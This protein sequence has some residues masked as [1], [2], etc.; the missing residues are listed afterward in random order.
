MSRNI[1]PKMVSVSKN[2]LLTSQLFQTLVEKLSESEIED[3][4][5]WLQLVED[6]KNNDKKIKR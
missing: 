6:E 1:Y 3:F 5:R 4:C 2:C